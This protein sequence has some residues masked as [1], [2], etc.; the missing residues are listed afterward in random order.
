MGERNPYGHAS[1]ELLER[2]ETAGVRNLR[3]DGDDAVDVLTDG[4]QIEIPCF[5]ACCATDKAVS[6]MAQAPNQE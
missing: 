3:T 4:Q 2:L 6:A 1:P 5:V